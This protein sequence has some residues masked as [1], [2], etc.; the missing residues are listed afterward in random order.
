VRLIPISN[1]RV[2][3]NRQRREFD[4]SALMELTESIQEIGLINPLTVRYDP[5]SEGVVLVAGE[6]RLRAIKDLWGMGGTLRCG[7]EPVE[8]GFVPAISIGDL[9]PIVAFETELEENIRRTDLS[10]QEKATAV[11]GLHELRTLQAQ[12]SGTVQRVADTATEI[13]GRSD[14]SYQDTVKKQIILAEHLDDPD[15]AGAASA[16]EAFKILER[17]EESREHAKRAAAIG[18]T[19]GA[20]SHKL[21]LGDC[22]TWMAQL[23]PA[24]FDVILTDPPYGMGADDFGDGAGRMVGITHDYK[25]D[26]TGFRALMQD[27]VQHFDRVAKPAAHLYI[28]CDLD[29]F[30]WLKETFNAAGWHVFRTPLIN[31]KINSGRVP[32][33]EHG[34]RRCYETILYAYRGDRRVTAIFPDVIQ[35]RGDDNLGHGA[36]KPVE[37]FVDLL[38]RSVRPGD[39]VLDP[40]C[41]TGTIF[42]ACHELRARATGIEREA[43][44]YG[45][46]VQRI[47]ELK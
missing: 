47:E 29:Q 19:F 23:E 22:R 13:H 38:R 32:L 8:E 4:P 14:G 18:A 3:E 16:K 26:V 28:C 44:Y 30:P 10:W 6:R 39:S 17:K 34:P 43:G 7:G 46:A 12:R 33:P 45:I 21:L 20:H 37:L 1:I 41:G 42:P 27:C 2:P 11:A 5:T 9:D 31:C 40:F 15:I 35:S 36:Q 25:D 24:S